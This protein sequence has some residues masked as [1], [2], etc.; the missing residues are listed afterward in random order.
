MFAGDPDSALA[1][2][3]RVAEEP[4]GRFAGV[5]LE[6]IY[7]IEDAGPREGLLP[8]GRIAYDEWRGERL[9]AQLLADSLYHTLPHGPLWAQVAL[10]LARLREADA[11]PAYALEP[12]LAVADSLPDDRLAPLARQRAGD[13]YRTQL[14]DDRRAL[15]QYEE[16]LARYPRAWNAAEVRRQVEQLRRDRRL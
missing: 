6:R 1:V 4:H 5:A 14:K 7:L 8:F 12:L 9:H 11:Q 3:Q 2:Y 15:E 16:C 10:T 13:I